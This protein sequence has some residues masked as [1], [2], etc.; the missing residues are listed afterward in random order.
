M[1]TKSESEN[2][3]LVNRIYGFIDIKT[4]EEASIGD[5]GDEDTNMYTND[6]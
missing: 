4:P 3:K 1:K 6:I 5:N 2:N